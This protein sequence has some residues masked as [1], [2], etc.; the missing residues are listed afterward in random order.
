MTGRK[1]DCVLFPVIRDIISW[2]NLQPDSLSTLKRNS[3]LPCVSPSP[4]EHQVLEY[5]QQLKEVALQVGCISPS[6]TAP[7][8]KNCEETRPAVISILGP[9]PAKRPLK[10]AS[11]ARTSNLW[12]MVPVGPCP[13]FIWDRRVS[14]GLNNNNKI[15][16]KKEA[17]VRRRRWG[18]VKKR[19]H[20]PDS[21]W[22]PQIRLRCHFRE[23]C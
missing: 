15:E 12:G 16:E 7:Y 4:E 2:W 6:L 3:S 21:G 10:P 13:L 8:I 14:A 20:L 23:I 22:Q 9:S 18:K 17:S 1:T 11:L 19:L 5:N